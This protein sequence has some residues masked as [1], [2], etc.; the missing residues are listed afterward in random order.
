METSTFKNYV[1]N[2]TF[3]LVRF[4]VKM[5]LAK[6]FVRLDLFIQ[7]VEMKILWSLHSFQVI[8]PVLKRQVCT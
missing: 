8:F 5:M 7:I 3:A 2:R 6:L 1:K 4:N